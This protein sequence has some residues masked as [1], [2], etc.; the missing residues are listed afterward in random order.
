MDSQHTLQRL[1]F[2]AQ[3]CLSFNQG[4]LYGSCIGSLLLCIGFNHTNTLLCVAHA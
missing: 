2:F 3:P 4:L 1:A